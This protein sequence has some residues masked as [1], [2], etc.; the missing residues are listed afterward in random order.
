M[1]SGVWA[2]T[3]SLSLRQI[4]GL[5]HSC[6]TRAYKI[7][8]QLLTPS[9]DRP[10]APQHHHAALNTTAGL[11]TATTKLAAHESARHRPPRR[12]DARLP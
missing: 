4:W 1:L 6:A 11:G 8:L 10:P 3:H 12:R 7:H 5:A 2:Q 9:T